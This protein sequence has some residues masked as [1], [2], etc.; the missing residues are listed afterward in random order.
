LKVISFDLDGTLFKKGLDDE[1]WLRLI[2][3][4]IA[5]QRSISIEEAK[6]YAIKEYDA[7]GSDDIRWYMPE[8]W[9]ERFNINT[10]IEHMLNRLDYSSALYDDVYAL[11]E[12]SRYRIVISTCNP[13]VMAKRKVKLLREKD[14]KIESVFSSISYGILKSSEFYMHV[15]TSLGVD[16]KSILHIGDNLNQDFIIPSSIGMNSLLIDREDKAYDHYK[17]YVI[18]SL[19]DLLRFL[20]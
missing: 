19:Y 2:P 7:I 14:I 8:Y 17:E 10:S 9:L 15:I 4:A 16:A 13:E 5:E 6:E 12:L 1:F 18:A 20:K 3:E 11:K